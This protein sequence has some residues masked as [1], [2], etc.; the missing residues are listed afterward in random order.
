MIAT[1]LKN[2]ENTINMSTNRKKIMNNLLLAL[3]QGR[4][5]HLTTTKMN[6]I[7]KITTLTTTIENS[8]NEVTTDN[9]VI[10]LMPMTMAISKD[11]VANSNDKSKESNSLKIVNRILPN[12]RAI[13]ATRSTK[14]S[15]NQIVLEIS[16]NHLKS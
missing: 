10:T 11:K 4:V 8:M 1:V 5:I 16:R 13:R 12:I 15:Q 7:G 14:G 2:Q 3:N 6:L 9:K